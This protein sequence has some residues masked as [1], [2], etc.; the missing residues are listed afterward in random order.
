[1]LAQFDRLA[2]RGSPSAR[3]DCFAGRG[4]KP[5]LEAISVSGSRPSAVE[6]HAGPDMGA[7]LMSPLRRIIAGVMLE[8]SVVV[9][10][11]DPDARSG[12]SEGEGG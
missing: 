8:R 12:H 6:N 9:D 10:Q 2:P 5:L 11:V 3:T 7:G 1:M 4:V